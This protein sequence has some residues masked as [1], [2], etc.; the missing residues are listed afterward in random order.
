MRNVAAA[1]VSNEL[2][3]RGVAPDER[4]VV[5]RK[6]DMLAL[7]EEIRQEALRRGMTQEMLDE[8]LREI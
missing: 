2:A 3:R 6:E 8:I 4:V 5:L 7:A 1:D